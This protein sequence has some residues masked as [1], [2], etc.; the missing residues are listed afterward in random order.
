LFYRGGAE[1]QRRTYF[2]AEAR[3]HREELVLPRRRG[4]AEKNIF[5]RGGAEA[6]RNITYFTAEAQGLIKVVFLVFLCIS[7]SPRF[8]ADLS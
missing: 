2:T 5:H 3:R 1:A 6:Q 7:P 4:G 8:I